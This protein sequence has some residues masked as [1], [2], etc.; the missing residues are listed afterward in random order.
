MSAICLLLALLIGMDVGEYLIVLII[1]IPQ[2]FSWWLIRNSCTYY[3][4]CLLFV[5]PLCMPR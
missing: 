5:L 3:L 2:S 4:T 1:A